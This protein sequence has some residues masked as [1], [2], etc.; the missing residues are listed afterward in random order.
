MPFPTLSVQ[1]SYRPGQALCPFGIS[2]AGGV[3]AHPES[4]PTAGQINDGAHPL[5]LA[6]AR[7]R[8]ELSRVAGN[9]AQV[10]PDRRGEGSMP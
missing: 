6:L 10:G 8:V 5:D 2:S 3:H 7:Q 9:L 1:I 4:A